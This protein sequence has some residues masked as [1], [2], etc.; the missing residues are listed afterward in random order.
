MYFRVMN[1][2]LFYVNA[3]NYG[4]LCTYHN[5]VGP[6]SGL[7]VPPDTEVPVRIVDFKTN[8]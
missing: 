2:V 3:E 7:R 4:L 8:R 6:L 1:N 5:T